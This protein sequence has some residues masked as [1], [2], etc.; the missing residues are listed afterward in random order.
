MIFDLFYLIASVQT[1]LLC[2]W[3]LRNNLKDALE[4][5]LSYWIVH[6]LSSDH[7]VQTSEPNNLKTK[8]FFFFLVSFCSFFFFYFLL[9]PLRHIPGIKWRNAMGFVRPFSPQRSW[10]ANLEKNSCLI[11]NLPWQVGFSCNVCLEIG[12]IDIAFRMRWAH[13]WRVEGTGQSSVLFNMQRRRQ[14]GLR[15]HTQQWCRDY[16][17]ES[18]LRCHCPCCSQMIR[19]SCSLAPVRQ[20]GHWFLFAEVTSTMDLSDWFNL[21][22][23]FRVQLICLFTWGRRKLRKP[24]WDRT[25]SRKENLRLRIK[26]WKTVGWPHSNCWKERQQKIL[27]TEGFRLRSK[28]T[29][30][31]AVLGGRCSWGDDSLQQ[32]VGSGPFGRERVVDTENDDSLIWFVWPCIGHPQDRKPLLCAL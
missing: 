28:Q 2:L 19:F 23:R 9:L 12:R 25:K 15:D 3:L 29:K 27:L 5:S 13:N 30:E 31:I 4:I 26:N 16:R 24:D 14:T 10:R 17:M 1:N 11:C 8:T 7:S 6:P 20:N 32:S 18:D 22:K 21:D